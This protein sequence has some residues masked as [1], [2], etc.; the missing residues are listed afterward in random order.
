MKKLLTGAFALVLSLAIALSVSG[1]TFIKNN[2]ALVDLPDSV[3]ASQNVIIN[4]YQDSTVNPNTG[5]KLLSMVD[6]VAKVERSSVAIMTES[7]SGSGVIIDVTDNLSSNNNTTVYIITCHHVISERGV[8]NVFIPDKNFSYENDDYIFGGIIGSPS[9]ANPTVTTPCYLPNTSTKM[10]YAVSLVG[11]DMQSDIAVL[12]LDL[13]KKSL[14]GKTLAKSDLCFANI[15]PTE[16]SAKRGE[17]VFAIGNPTGILPGSVCSGVI[18]YLERQATVETVGSMTLMQIDAP[19]NPGSSG[20]GLYNLYGELIGITNSGNTN[21]NSTNFAIPAS[22]SVDAE[23]I[24]NG[25]VS[26]AAQL[27]ATCTDQNY[28]YVTGRK[29]K[30][31]M[32]V[33]NGTTDAGSEYVYV[34]SITEGSKAQSLI[35]TNVTNP[36]DKVR[37]LKVKDVI[38]SVTV[39]DQTTQATSYNAFTKVMEGLKIDDKVELTIS[40]IVNNV[41]SATYTFSYTVNQFVF[42]GAKA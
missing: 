33:T 36:L 1:C 20:G 31:G 19:T 8:V 14:S 28:G 9:D 21:F 37:G 42:C 39:N 30:I 18:S 23:G 4:S 34:A 2:N 25:F 15:A 40:R 13:T 11:G 3:T 41:F 7:G 10:D 16:Y 5:R 26:I 29:E 32:G 22:T 12:K 35:G 24:N 17:T 6:A 38:L 27:I